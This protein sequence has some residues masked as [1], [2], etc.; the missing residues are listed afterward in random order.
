MQYLSTDTCKQIAVAAVLG[1]GSYLLKTMPKKRDNDYGLFENTPHLKGH[2][3]LCR[4]IL[5]LVN[6]EQLD[7]L[8]DLINILEGVLSTAS[9]ISKSPGSMRSNRQ[10]NDVNV[11][12]LHAQ[13][14]MKDL[15]KKA[16]MSKDDDIIMHCIDFISDEHE[17]YEGILESILHNTMLDTFR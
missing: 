5:K 2:D 16:K 12:I 10:A 11:L 3:N 7:L 13:Q 6:L 17:G 8:Y 9:Y 4:I 15:L 1:T 14:K